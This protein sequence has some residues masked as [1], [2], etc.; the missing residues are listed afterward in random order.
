[1]KQ[2]LSKKAI[3]EILLELRQNALFDGECKKVLEKFIRGLDKTEKNNDS[4]DYFST[5]KDIYYVLS[6]IRNRN[7][8]K[9]DEQRKLRDAVVGFFGLSVGSHAATTWLMESRADVVKI[10][11]YDTISPSNLNRLRASW[12]E[13]GTFKTESLEKRLKE[14]NPYV[15]II[16]SFRRDERSVAEIFDGEPK[17]SVVVDEIDSIEGKII[18]RKLAK[19]R[20]IPLISAVD[21]GDN[22]VLDIER[23]D[24]DLQLKPFLG[25]I[26]DKELSNCSKFSDI[27]RKKLIIKL[28]GFEKNSEVMLDSLLSIGESIGTWPQ[29]G[30]TATLAGGIIATTIKKII[31]QENIESGRYY[32]SLDD[33]LVKDFSNIERIRERDKKITEIK[34]RFKLD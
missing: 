3:E 15:S 24:K 20:Q 32:F 6:T 21:V 16:S 7:L 2:R 23:Y 26:S 33:I 30:A 5:I 28:V 19:Q 12:D 27:D 9:K 14:I 18:L 10:V 11:D 4:S 29:L 13:I 1:M 17:L 8:I 25:R 34:L 31:L 22:V